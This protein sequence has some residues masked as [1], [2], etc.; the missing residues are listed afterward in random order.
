MSTNIHTWI[1]RQSKEDLLARIGN[2]SV[3]VWGAYS[4]G[5]DL[6]AYFES[7][8]ARMGGYVDG[9]KACSEFCGS[10]VIKP[11]ELDKDK[12][13]PVIAVSG[14][15]SEICNHLTFRGFATGDDYLYISKEIPNVCISSVSGTYKDAYGNEV[16]NDSPNLKM[17]L[18][19][20]GYDNKIYIGRDVEMSEGVKLLLSGG[21]N[22]QIGSYCKIG[23]EIELEAT[24]GGSLVLGDN[25]LMQG[26]SRMSAEE[27]RIQFGNFVSVGSGFFAIC[28]EK[29][30]VIVGN[31]CMLSKDVTLLSTD[32]HSIIDL[33]LKK[34]LSP[35]KDAEVQIGEHVW[36]GKGAVI[37]PGTRIEKGSI[38]GAL[39]LVKGSFE[40]NTTIAG[41]PA[42]IINVGRTWDRRRNIKFEEL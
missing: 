38:V 9:H 27:G 30:P 35:E 5:H 26:R 29:A 8:G 28:S 6:Y 7:I 13:F 15:R 4:V 1:T 21:G 22:I 19:I 2:K 32:S 39:S 11:E 42:K 3:Y 40:G 20:E 18:R 37:M 10:P 41:N 31:D 33:N 23:N 24:A 16:V 36:I 17:S 14:I 25:C 12:M 34:N